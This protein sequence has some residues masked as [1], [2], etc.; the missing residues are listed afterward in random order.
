MLAEMEPTERMKILKL[1][2][3]GTLNRERWAEY[4]LDPFR[5]WFTSERRMVAHV[6][7]A[8]KTA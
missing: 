3:R 7:T 8:E 1:V 6:D 4:R 2:A 5:D